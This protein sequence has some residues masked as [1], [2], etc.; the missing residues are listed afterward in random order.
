MKNIIKILDIQPITHDV[1]QFRVEKPSGYKFIPGQAAKV[2]IN[3]EDL[4]EEKRS[5][6]FSSLNED[7]YL[8][9]II[10]AYPQHQGITEKIHQLQVGDELIIGDPR[11]SIHYAD[12]GVFIAGG[13]GITPFIAILRQLHKDGKVANSRLLFS[14]KTAG[15][16]IL[17]EELK[18]MLPSENL[19]LVFTREESS[20]YHFGRMDR[21]FLKGQIADFSQN[22]Y[23]CGPR[24]MTADI[25]QALVDLG[26]SPQLLVFEK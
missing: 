7:P 2:A 3:R 1:K 15:D 25:R 24:A 10:K 8:E 9:F 16:V 19:T 23:I 18:G 21:A 5:F 17:E 6:T 22:F 12:Q 13:A 14:N 11:G 20:G 26:A 4:L